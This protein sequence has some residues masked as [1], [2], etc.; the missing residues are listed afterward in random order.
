MKYEQV[1]LADSLPPQ[2]LAALPRR[3]DCPA[4][5]KSWFIILPKVETRGFPIHALWPHARH[6]TPKVRVVVD[7]LASRFLLEPPWD[8]N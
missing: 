7:E 1:D 2:F 4:G 8:R 6:M 5:N 3:L